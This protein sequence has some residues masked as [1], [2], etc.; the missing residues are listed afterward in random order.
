MSTFEKNESTGTTPPEK[1]EHLNHAQKQL[2]MQKEYNSR[3]P[4]NP[5]FL[6]DLKDLFSRPVIVVNTRTV[7]PDKP[8]QHDALTNSSP[9][10]KCHGKTN[11][12]TRTT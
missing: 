9:E 10:N 4:K 11:Q 7:L 3:T 12:Q 8:E 5:Q 1:T 6:Q 2:A